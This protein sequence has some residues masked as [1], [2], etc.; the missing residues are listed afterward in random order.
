MIKKLKITVL[1]ETYDVTVE[2][3]S[4]P[5]E[6]PVEAPVSPDAAKPAPIYSETKPVIEVKSQLSGVISAIAVN[7]GDEV[8]SGD[9]LCTIEM[10]KMQNTIPSPID[11]V[12]TGIL[13]RVGDSVEPDALLITLE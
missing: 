1:G 3:V 10:L 2:D 12:V 6:A 13:V 9:G 7:I 11:G 5:A 8:S 4:D